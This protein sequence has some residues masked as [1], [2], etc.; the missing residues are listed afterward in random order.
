MI[1]KSTESGFCGVLEGGKKTQGRSFSN[2]L[3]FVVS[4]HNPYGSWQNPV[5]S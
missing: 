1:Q 4:L 3:A 5:N 2:I